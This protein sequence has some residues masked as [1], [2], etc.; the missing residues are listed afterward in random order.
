M[1][2]D[3]EALK[4]RKWAGTEAGNRGDPPDALRA[5]GW[6]EAYSQVGGIPG[7]ER[8]YVNQLLC[9]LTALGVEIVTSG[10]PPEWAASIDYAHPAFCRGSDGLLYRSVASSG[11]SSGSATD[12][13]T[14]AAR[15][16]WRQY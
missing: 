8:L 9:E 5:T 1:P 3:A 15:T 16:H 4:I 13:V 7:P 6:H 11:P 2:T 14:D 10:V 12:P